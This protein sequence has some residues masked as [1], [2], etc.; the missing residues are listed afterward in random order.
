MLMKYALNRL[1]YLPAIN[2]F[3]RLANRLSVGFMFNAN[4]LINLNSP[5]RLIN[6]IVD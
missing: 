3:L 1:K 6:K 2:K 4:A 5:D